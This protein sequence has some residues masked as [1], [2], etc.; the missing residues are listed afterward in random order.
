MYVGI[1]PQKSDVQCF[2]RVMRT[3]HTSAHF[4][5]SYAIARSLDL[6]R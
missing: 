3:S 4:C 1:P 5:T 6:T 2:H